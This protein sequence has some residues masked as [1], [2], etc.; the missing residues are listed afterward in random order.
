[1]PQELR[2]S[3]S[4]NRCNELSYGELG[5]SVNAHEMTELPFYRLHLGH[6]EMEEPDGLP[7][8]FLTLRLVAV[9][10]RKTRDAMSQQAST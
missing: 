6:V 3:L 8:E 9:D 5:G 1:M 4:V 10:I 2:G 7:F